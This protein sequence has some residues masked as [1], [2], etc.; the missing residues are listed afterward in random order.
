MI[1]NIIIRID[2]FSGKFDNCRFEKYKSNKSVKH[3]FLDNPLILKKKE[4]FNGPL[5]LIFNV[6]M[7]L[8]TITH[9]LRKWYF[10]ANSLLDFTQLSFLK[11]IKYLA[12]LLDISPDEILK[13]SFTK[14]EIGL[15]IVLKYD[16]IS[17]IPC[18]VK[19]STFDRW[20]C[21]TTTV[22]FVGDDRE[23][24]LYDKIEKIDD[25]EDK[26]LKNILKK[27]NY[28]YIRIE[29]TMN[30]QKSY[31]YR[32][33]PKI[34]TIKDLYDNFIILYTFWAM[35]VA[36]IVV[37][38]N[39]ILSPKM[40]FEDYLIAQT[41]LNVDYTEVLQHAKDKIHGANRK[42]KMIAKINDVI[43]K[44]SDKNEFN[45]VVFKSIIF[46]NLLRINKKE[47]QMN[48]IEIEKILK[49]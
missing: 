34:K 42:S 27:Y 39:I 31:N 17:I 25:G 33:L 3:Y 36:I 40:N 5:K 47:P 16:I 35:E 41:L 20:T 29:I 15:N 11:A 24:I 12:L 49:P 46:E 43:K 23:L 32:N 37:K 19:Y 48:I 2:K 10:G 45:S 26:I 22:K 4:D 7:N 6:E 9:S 8:L 14:C 38:N 30:D 28:S 13:S 21:G 18:F 44:Y 1:D